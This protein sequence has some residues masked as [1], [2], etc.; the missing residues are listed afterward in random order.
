MRLREVTPALW[1]G[2]VLLRPGWCEYMFLVDGVWTLDPDAPEKAP[3]GD[4]DFSSARRIG[5]CV[6]SETL[7]SP[8]TGTLDSASVERVRESAA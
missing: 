6:R 2:E 5:S 7:P 8:K 3:D 4:G 1:S